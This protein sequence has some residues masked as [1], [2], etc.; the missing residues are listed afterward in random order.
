MLCFIDY[1]S[2]CLAVN[3]IF[4]H[5]SN[6]NLGSINFFS[7]YINN[8]FFS[9]KNKTKI[10]LSKHIELFSVLQ[11]E[12]C[13]RDR[14]RVYNI[15]QERIGPSGSTEPPPPALIHTHTHTHILGL[16]E[17]KLKRGQRE[18]K[19][20][21]SFSEVRG[22]QASLGQSHTDV[23]I[24]A[25][26]LLKAEI[27]KF[28]EESSHFCAQKLTSWTAFSYTVTWHPYLSFSGDGVLKQEVCTLGFLNVVITLGG[29]Q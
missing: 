3:Y 11:E 14:I 17:N 19:N 8:T 12:A 16:S 23:L 20:M 4:V 9:K 10:H 25:L 29:K 21:A 18:S 26:Q 27:Y 15:V 5:Y 7:I 28:T 2:K 22:W 1:H 13:S 6:K 24:R